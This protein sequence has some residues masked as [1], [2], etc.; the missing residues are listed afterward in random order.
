MPLLL[1]TDPDGTSRSKSEN[2]TYCWQ[3]AAARPLC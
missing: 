2:P 1:L 3:V